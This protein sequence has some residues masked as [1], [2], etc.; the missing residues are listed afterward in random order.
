MLIQTLLDESKE[1][2]EQLVSTLT[3]A[4]DDLNQ[5]NY[6][7]TDSNSQGSEPNLGLGEDEPKPSMAGRAA[8]FFRKKS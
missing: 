2:T 6:E 5:S 7:S 8:R 1:N 3:P 4:E